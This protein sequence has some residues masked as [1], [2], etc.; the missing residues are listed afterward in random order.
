LTEFTHTTLLARQGIY[1]KAGLVCAYELLY[2]SGDS[3]AS[4]L[5][6][7][8]DKA[9]DSATS[10]LITQ[11]FTNTDMEL[12]LGNK[13][14]FINFTRN[15]LLERLPMILPKNRIVIE[16]LENIEIDQDLIDNIIALH[17][18]GYKI[19]LDDFVF[20]EPLIPLMEVADIIKI[21]VLHLNKVEIQ[22]KLAVLNNFQGK[23]LAEKIEHQQQL[24]IC[25]ELGFHYFQGFFLNKPDLVKGQI[26]SDNKPQLIR[27]LSELFNPNV[28]IHQVEKIIL[29]VPKLSY[30]VL[31]LANSAANYVGKR[32]NSLADA[33]VQL[34]LIQIRNWINLLLASSINEVVDDLLERTLIRAKMCELLAEHSSM[35]NPHL[36][37]TVGMLSTID[38]M[39]N[40]PMTSLLDKIRLNDDLN[41][42]LKN[43][44]GSLGHL[45]K[46][47]IL[48]EQGSFNELDYVGFTPDIYNQAYLSGIEHANAVMIMLKIDK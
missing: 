12:V 31:R 33:I 2:R 39:L 36:A 32:F 25:A 21:D 45:L 47:T 35:A 30:R 11:L 22:E 23:L 19:A 38:A 8:H 7:R 26:I 10:F 9:S 34:G 3:L 27:L 46:Q 24:K 29:Q 40:E 18:Q 1:N 6:H 13:R 20:E 15:H 28:Q 44:Q 17:R 43:Q 37:H 5:I 16:I 42:A 48:Y 41:A 14:G 4:N